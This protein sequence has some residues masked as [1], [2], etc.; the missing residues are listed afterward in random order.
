[1]PILGQWNCRFGH[2]YQFRIELYRRL[3]PFQTGREPS[4]VPVDHFSRI[5]VGQSLARECESRR[6]NFPLLT[7]LRGILNQFRRS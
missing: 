6:G 4:R 7:E 5:N 3:V 2:E 1:M